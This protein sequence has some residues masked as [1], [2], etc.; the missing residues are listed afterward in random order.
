MT[1]ETNELLGPTA[2]MLFKSTLNEVSVKL[3]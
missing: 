3:K 1:A 2:T